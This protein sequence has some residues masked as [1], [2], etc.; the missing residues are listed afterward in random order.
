MKQIPKPN[1]EIRNEFQAQFSLRRPSRL[2]QPLCGS[3]E[4]RVVGALLDFGTA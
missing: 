4:Y 3:E 1:I 2:Q